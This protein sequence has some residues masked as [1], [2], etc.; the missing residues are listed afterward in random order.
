MYI[1][2]MNIIKRGEVPLLGGEANT[3]RRAGR[4]SVPGKAKAEREAGRGAFAAKELREAGRKSGAERCI[5][6][7]Q[8]VKNG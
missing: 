4:E 7:E 2:L 1:I 5:F 3:G 6:P 8:E